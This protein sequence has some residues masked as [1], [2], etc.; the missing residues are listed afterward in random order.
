MH[1]QIN[2]KSVARIAAIQTFYQFTSTSQEYDINSSLARIKDF[3]KDANIKSDYDLGKKSFLKLKP[4]Y[5]YLEELVKYT[6]DNLSEIDQII[7]NHLT[8][9]RTL[10][11]M[12]VLLIALLRVGIC[13]LTYFPE[14]PRKVVINE[15][16]DIA[17]DM[18]EE[19]ETGF[20]N[21]V[22][23]NYANLPTP[24]GHS[25]ERGNPEKSVIKL[26]PRFHG[27]DK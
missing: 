6:Y 23:H 26:D 4:S 16:T 27:E 1:N 3:Y 20:V 12:P 8:E 5:A 19:K 11:T 10:K 2:T 18:L 21:S 14:T 17:S 22:L 25:R 24:Q 13:E 9:G 15:Y 7:T